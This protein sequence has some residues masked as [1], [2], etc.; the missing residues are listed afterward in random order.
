[1]GKVFKKITKPIAKVFDK[2]IPNEIKPA[3]PYLAAA[4]PFL[5]PGA[6]GF[7][8]NGL[9]SFGINNPMI[10]RAILSG[11]LNTVSQLSQEGAAER[12]I[13]PLSLAMA[14]G[15]GAL[16]TPGAPGT[17]QGSQIAGNSMATGAPI[18]Q[19]AL[20]GTSDLYGM[21]DPT[22]FQQ[23]Q[24]FGLEGL[25]KGAEFLGKG[26]SES[27]TLKEMVMSGA[28]SVGA[29]ATEQAYN[30]ALDAK[31]AYEKEYADWQNFSGQQLANFNSGRRQAI[32]ASMTAAQ[33]GE[34]VISSTLAQLGLRDGGRVGYKDAGIVSLTDENSG[35]I[36]R[37][38]DTGE[39]ITSQEFLGRADENNSRPLSREDILQFYSDAQSASGLFNKVIKNRKFDRNDYGGLERIRNEYTNRKYDLDPTNYP[40]KKELMDAE[41]YFNK[42]NDETREQDSEMNDIMTEQGSKEFS[43][44]YNSGK[45]KYNSSKGIQIV[46]DK[47]GIPF[48]KAKDIKNIFESKIDMKANGGIIGLMNG[49]Q[50]VEMDYR[51]GGMIPIGSKER[52]D[53]VPA[54]LSKNEFVMTAD[55]VRAAGGGS[56]NE[57]AR[58]MYELMNNLEARA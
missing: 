33:L 20:G 19:A 50:P 1:M 49:G 8:A 30:A 38:P 16:T 23:A 57:G 21:T 43:K 9:A 15:T 42:I 53:D 27:S 28:P 2:I 32:I 44:L 25:S 47:L 48:D 18:T 45:V 17:L 5:A 7:M 34:D 39:S 6:Y 51:M 46:A 22:L 31:N 52:A 11:G 10:Q 26:A 4:F 29:A 3:L 37:D 36:Y 58:R 24:N 13:N 12:G 14:A 54:R 56:V 55:A 40:D 41:K 35:V